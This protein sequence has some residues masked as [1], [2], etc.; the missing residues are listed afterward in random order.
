[1]FV[2]MSRLLICTM[3]NID[4]LSAVLSLDGTQEKENVCC[5]LMEKRSLA[6]EV[7]C[8]VGWSL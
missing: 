4:T 2:E 3:W 1:M 7:L 6:L 5:G 8:V